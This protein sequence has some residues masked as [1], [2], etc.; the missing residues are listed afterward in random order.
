MTLGV[1]V[2]HYS[3]LVSPVGYITFKGLESLLLEA[4]LLKS[5]AAT[6]RVEEHNM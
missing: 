3:L 5:N 6:L 1:V 2:N 4:K